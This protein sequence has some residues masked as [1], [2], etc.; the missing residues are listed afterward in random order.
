MLGAG[1]GGAG[2]GGGATGKHWACRGVLC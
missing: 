2:V 1:A